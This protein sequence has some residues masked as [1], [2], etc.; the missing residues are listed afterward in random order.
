[1]EWTEAFK[2]EMRE[3]YLRQIKVYMIFGP[4][5]ILIAFPFYYYLAIVKHKFGFG[6]IYDYYFLPLLF[7]YSCFCLLTFYVLLKKTPWIHLTSWII[8]F[9]DVIAVTF[10]TYCLG[11]PHF[12]AIALYPMVIVLYSIY[13]HPIMATRFFILSMVL[14]IGV[15]LL[16][17][18]EI[19]PFSP[20]IRTNIEIFT[21]FN[22]YATKPENYLLTILSYGLVAFLSFETLV[23]ANFIVKKLRQREDELSLSNQ[24][25]RQKA[26]QISRLSEKLKVYLPHQFVESLAHGDRDT[27][28]D[29]RRRRLT[30]FFSDI[31][32]FT[33]WTDKLEPEEVRELLNQYLS[34]M[35]NIA[36]KWAE[37]ST[38]LSG[39]RLWSFSAIRSSPTIRTTQSGV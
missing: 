4:P 20:I 39:T 27:E 10:I 13:I 28:P 31:R 8:L 25:T 9:A 29:Y 19:I 24:E 5:L 22:D 32:G 18:R 15:T 34:E 35:S 16:A 17:L 30:I 7:T 36:K 12:S 33:K 26:E 2:E 1:M 37:Q 21:S 3:R 11:A 38:S 6:G 23:I 14:L